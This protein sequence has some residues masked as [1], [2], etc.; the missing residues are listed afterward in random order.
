MRGNIPGNKRWVEAPRWLG[1]KVLSNPAEDNFPFGTSHEIPKRVFAAGSPVLLLAADLLDVKIEGGRDESGWRTV[2]C[3]LLGGGGEA[4]RPRRRTRLRRAPESRSQHS[5]HTEVCM[6]IRARVRSAQTNRLAL[7]VHCG[8]AEVQWSPSC[9]CGAC[10]AFVSLYTFPSPRLTTFFAV[11]RLRDRCWYPCE[12]HTRVCSRS[13]KHP[14]NNSPKVCRKWIRWFNLMKEI[15]KWK[16]N[17]RMSF[18]PLDKIVWQCVIESGE[19]KSDK[20]KRYRSVVLLY[21]LKFVD[22]KRNKFERQRRGPRG[23]NPGGGGGGVGGVRR[24]RGRRGREKKI[25]P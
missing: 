5:Q 24:S 7:S 12:P 16:L 15:N 22:E 6:G 2:V 21:V 8:A 20:I 14:A 4:V 18:I 3:T 25:V 1:R 11:D 13:A 9:C 17:I 19:A 10:F 23:G